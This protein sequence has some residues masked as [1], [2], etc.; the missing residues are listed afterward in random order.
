MYIEVEA[1]TSDI[2]SLDQNQE[3]FGVIVVAA[4]AA[5]VAVVVVVTVVLPKLKRS[6]FLGEIL[7][8]VVATVVLLVTVAVLIPVFELPP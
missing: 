6:T 5:V 1:M 7:A 4:V 2:H 3:L 8:F